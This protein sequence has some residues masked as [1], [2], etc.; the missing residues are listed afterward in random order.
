MNVIIMQ[1]LPGS[2]KSTFAKEA[3][4]LVVSADDFFVEL[5]RGTYTFDAAR[6]SEAHG[7]CF[8][9]FIAAVAVQKTPLVIV[10]NTNTTPMEISPYYLAA[11]AFGY[12]AEIVR[13]E[14]PTYVA[15]ARNTHGVLEATI[16]AMAKRMDE[17]PLPPWWKLRVVKGV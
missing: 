14:C 3:G 13:V 2:G 11:Q 7:Q 12:D 16:H 17:S 4:G 10:D 9:R 8:R 1:G 15:A 6:L 5:G